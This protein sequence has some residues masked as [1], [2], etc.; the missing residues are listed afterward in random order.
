MALDVTFI[1]IHLERILPP[2]VSELARAHSQAT[3]TLDLF[4]Y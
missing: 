2:E 3:S 1:L 4:P